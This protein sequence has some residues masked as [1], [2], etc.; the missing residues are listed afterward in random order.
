MSLILFV[1]MLNV[2]NTVSHYAD[3]SGVRLLSQ[4]FAQKSFI[5]QALV[6][7]TIETIV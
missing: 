3:C 2:V 4:N 7:F 1:I 6:Y 5:K